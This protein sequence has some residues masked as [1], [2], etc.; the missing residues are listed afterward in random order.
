MNPQCCAAHCRRPSSP[1]APAPH[2]PLGRTLQV[3]APL[4]EVLKKSRHHLT[5]HQLW[6]RRRQ[7]LLALPAHQWQEGGA[8][9]RARAAVSGRNSSGGGGLR[10]CNPC[11]RR[12]DAPAVPS[13]TAALRPLPRL[14][15][16]PADK[17]D[18]Y[19]RALV[20]A[21][22]ASFPKYL[23]PDNLQVRYCGRVWVGAE[24]ASLC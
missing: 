14:L 3:S 2:L 5:P 12:R 13:S 16:R 11:T 22:L 6:E 10:P 8:L 18:R 17:A 15:L 19:R 21:L 23:T 7:Q 20:D 4:Y 1:P 9:E 24:G